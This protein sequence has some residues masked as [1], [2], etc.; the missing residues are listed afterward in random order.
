VGEYCAVG[1]TGTGGS[2][3]CWTCCRLQTDRHRWQ[4]N[5]LDMLQTT[6]RQA[7]VAVQC[8]GHA[9]GYRQPGT[10]GSTM[11]WTCCRLQT[12]RHRWQYNVL[13]MLQA[14]DT[15]SEYSLILPIAL[16]LLQY[17][18]QLASPLRH[19]HTLPVCQYY[20]PPYLRHVFFRRHICCCYVRI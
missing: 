7:Q 16:P 10:G 17:L 15:H 14:T 11:C 13:D 1:Q 4:Y 8:A 12:G 20:C 2:T 18:H 9:A 19:T 3:M 6:D 5:V